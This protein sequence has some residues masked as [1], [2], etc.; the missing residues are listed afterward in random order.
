MRIIR[1]E[2]LRSIVQLILRTPSIIVASKIKKYRGTIVFDFE[3]FPRRSPWLRHASISLPPRVIGH[4]FVYTPWLRVYTPDSPKNSNL[5]TRCLTVNHGLRSL[6]LYFSA[7]RAKILSFHDPL[8]DRVAVLSFHGTGPD[9]TGKIHA[10]RDV[11]FS[12]KF[13]RSIGG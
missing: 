4:V 13:P 3:N 7:W 6:R 1:H 9:S 12:P 5:L 2:I 8:G 11:D 10:R